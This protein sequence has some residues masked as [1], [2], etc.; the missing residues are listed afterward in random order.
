MAKVPARIVKALA[1]AG[2]PESLP[3]GRRFLVIGPHV[4]G[5]GDTFAEAFTNARREG[6]GVE[7]RFL[8][9]DAPANAR[10]DGM[11]YIAWTPI[12]AD[13]TVNPESRELLKFGK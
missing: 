4:W 8:L 9:F 12:E 6:P 13:G 7:K 5:R 3:A 10:V 1:A 2:V 11:G